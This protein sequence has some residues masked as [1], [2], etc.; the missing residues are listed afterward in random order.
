M[1]ATTTASA[2]RAHAQRTTRPP[3]KIS[4]ARFTFVSSPARD[5][6]SA[7]HPRMSFRAAGPNR[8]RPLNTAVAIVGDSGDQRR[9]ATKPPPSPC[10]TRSSGNLAPSGR[11]SATTTPR[12]ALLPG[13]ACV[14]NATVPLRAPSCRKRRMVR[15]EP[16]ASLWTSRRRYSTAISTPEVLAWIPLLSCVQALVGLWTAVTQRCRWRIDCVTPAWTCWM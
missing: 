12:G 10:V 6:S 4:F 16:R 14:K 11:S 7:A 3:N 9:F 2:G 1:S 8:C 5:P 15:C 13:I